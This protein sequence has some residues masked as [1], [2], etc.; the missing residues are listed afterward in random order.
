[1]RRQIKSR[2]LIL[3]GRDLGESDRIITFL[4]RDFG[5]LSAVAKGAKRSARRFAGCLELFSLVEVCLD[6]RGRELLRL[7][8]CDLAQPFPAIRSDL[9]RYAVACYLCELARELFP[10]REPAADAFDL[11]AHALG[12]LDAGAPYP[13][14]R[15]AE[16]RLLA[17]AG[18]RPALAACHAC[19]AEPEG[20]AVRFSPE[21]GGILCARCASGEAGVIEVSAGTLRLLEE[22]LRLEVARLSR[23]R[24]SRLA[25]SESEALLTAV[26]RHTLR[27]DLKS[28][29]FLESLG[30]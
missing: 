20:L 10:E 1:L 27:K 26:V 11:L 28:R 23:L 6:D 12:Q 14:E 7:E 15:V 5:K 13:W 22:A 2:A 19:G 25:L 9:K 4:T 3:G 30:T 16:L 8:S 24:F 18:F 29:K 17:L 21:R